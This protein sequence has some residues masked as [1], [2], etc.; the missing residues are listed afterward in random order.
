[1][2]DTPLPE[3]ALTEKDVVSA[4]PLAEMPGIS[5]AFFTRR[6]G[7]SE[8]VYAGLNAG[9][10]AGDQP[11]AV[12]EN[13]ARAM[14]FLG[15]PADRLAMPWQVHSAEAI[16]VDAPFEGERPKLDA[17]VTATPGLA[18]AVL[19]ADCGP[20]LFADPKAGL[21]G[22]AHSGWKGALG[23]ILEATVKAMESC[24]AHRADIRAVLGPA[25]TRENYEVGVDLAET[26]AAADRRFT[27]FFSPGRTPDKRQFDLPGLI[28]ARLEAAG[29]EAS[30]VGRCT[31]AE[32]DLFYSYR[33]M[34]HRGE[35][36]YGRQL[37]AIA[38]KG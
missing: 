25:I 13:R 38:L 12:R 34:T 1:M 35:A 11:E 22:A 4:P 36:D 18:V 7:V 3:P 23:D 28:L 30:F 31:Y 20:V 16:V 10:G 14:R 24:G 5:H 6:G 32:E 15:I 37:S 27:R 33:R 21:V 26:F 9:I 17:V 19:T 29:V 8:G 2:F